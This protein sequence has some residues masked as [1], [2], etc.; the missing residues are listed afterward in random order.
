MNNQIKRGR[1]AKNKDMVYVI[2]NKEP[3]YRLRSNILWRR[4]SYN[5]DDIEIIYYKQNKEIS[6]S[7][8]E[9]KTI[10]LEQLRTKGITS[11][12]DLVNTDLFFSSNGLHDIVN[13]EN[14]LNLD[15]A[16]NLDNKIVYFNLAALISP[17]KEEQK[18]LW[19]LGIYSGISPVIFIGNIKEH[20]LKGIYQTLKFK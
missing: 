2:K 1:P 17:T 10:Q 3:I 11:I 20:Q 4:T 16:L 5:I 8:G 9:T 18:T 13:I 14:V 6:V 12:L 7:S 15:L 19:N